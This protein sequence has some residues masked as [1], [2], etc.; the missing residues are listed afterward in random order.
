MEENKEEYVE[1]VLSEDIDLDILIKSVEEQKKQILER[2]TNN[3]WFTRQLVWLY[4]YTENMKFLI[5]KTHALNKLYFYSFY[6]YFKGRI[7][8]KGPYSRMLDMSKEISI[9]KIAKE[10]N[11]FVL[12]ALSFYYTPYKIVKA[13]IDRRI[14]LVKL[15]YSVICRNDFKSVKDLLK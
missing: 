11:L 13:I 9:P 14:D 12:K 7:K 3:K 6:Y 5:D 4:I 8:N 1:D 10:N 15:K 2:Y